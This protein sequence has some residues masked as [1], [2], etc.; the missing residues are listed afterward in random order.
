MSVVTTLQKYLLVWVAVGTILFAT[1]LPAFAAIDTFTLY[2]ASGSCG[3]IPFASIHFEWVRR[4]RIRIASGESINVTLYGNGADFAQDAVGSDI[5]ESISGRGTTTD[6]PNAPIMFG[7]KVAKGY[8][9]VNVRAASSR[10]LGNR[11]VT[12]KW[13]IGNEK[14]SL[15]IVANCSDLTSADYRRPTSGSGNGTPPS[16]PG[17]PPSTPGTP[18]STPGTPPSTPGTPVRSIPNL[19]PALTTPSVLT[20]PLF[21]VISTPGGGMTQVN[22][23]FC[24]GLAVNTVATVAVPKLTWGVS[25]VNNEAA[26][27]RFDVQLI[28][29]DSN[30][31]LDTLTL[32]QGFSDNTP[33][34]QRDNYPGRAASIRVIMNPRFQ[35]GTAMQT[36][37]GCF[38]EPGSTQSLDP[39]ALLIKVDPGNLIDESN[40]ENDNELRF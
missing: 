28:D 38:T 22:S 23:F 12:V 19:L 33:L 37:I 26:N 39:K 31:T 3:N 17:T 7:S 27:T 9:R 1:P 11:T 35:F 32:A 29:A 13:P 4:K 15:K 24:S 40:R 10:G 6:Y 36:T 34:V 5:Y 25:G 20:R 16:T 30:R 18:P 21:G 14:F 8:V 2:H